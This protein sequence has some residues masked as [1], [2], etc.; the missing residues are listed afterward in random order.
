VLNFLALI[1]TKEGSLNLNF[2]DDL[3][4]GCCITHDGKV[5]HEKVRGERGMVNSE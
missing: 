2:N 1:I 3:V 4:K 5:V